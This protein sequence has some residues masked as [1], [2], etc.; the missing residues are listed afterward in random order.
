MCIA[1]VFACI[2]IFSVSDMFDGDGRQETKPKFQRLTDDS[3]ADSTQ[4]SHRSV[5]LIVYSIS[6]FDIFFSAYER[7]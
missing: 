3:T 2:Q 6:L 7:D 5:C 4:G 1:E